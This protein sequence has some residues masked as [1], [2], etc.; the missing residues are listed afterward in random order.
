[1]TSQQDKL[2]L[3]STIL[4]NYGM[5]I[6]TFK[7]AR[8]D[9]TTNIIMVTFLCIIFACPLTAITI[10]LFFAAKP[11]ISF[12]IVLSLVFCLI[13][14]MLWYTIWAPKNIKLIIEN[15]RL[16]IRSLYGVNIPLADLRLD[17]AQIFTNAPKTMSSEGPCWR[18]NGIGM[19]GLSEGRFRS[20]NL[21]KKF[22]VFVTN[23]KSI[24][25]IPTTRS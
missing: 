14:S 22:R 3:T 21:K 13:G 9:V 11:P 8:P 23:E 24:V 17:E 12:I 20:F 25:A 7:L 1:L 5:Q 10:A 15:G 16:H 18:T 6:S 4:R 2:E 19:P